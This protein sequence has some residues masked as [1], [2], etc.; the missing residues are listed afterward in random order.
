MTKREQPA[1][2]EGALANESLAHLVILLIT[3]LLGLKALFSATT[4][5][6]LKNPQICPYMSIYG[7]IEKQKKDLYRY[8]DI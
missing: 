8:I 7:Y 3:V 6:K 2:V 5:P 4:E 1:G